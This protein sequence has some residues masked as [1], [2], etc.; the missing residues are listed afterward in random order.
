LNTD[1]PACIKIFVGLPQT[2]KEKW[3]VIVCGN[4]TR[5]LRGAGFDY[6][7]LERTL[8]EMVGFLLNTETPDEYLHEIVDGK[9]Q[10][11]RFLV[12]HYLNPGLDLEWGPLG[13]LAPFWEDLQAVVKADVPLPRMD[14]TPFLASGLCSSKSE[15]LTE[16]ARTGT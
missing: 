14:G 5:A 12:G 11:A 1:N 4:G 8:S 7:D 16:T 15:T 2:V 9:H 10:R 13:D 3:I 6:A